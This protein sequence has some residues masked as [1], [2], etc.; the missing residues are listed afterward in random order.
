MYPTT[1]QLYRCLRRHAREQQ[2]NKTV[3]TRRKR[4]KLSEDDRPAHKQMCD[5]TPHITHLTCDG[6]GYRSAFDMSLDGPCP[7]QTPRWHGHADATAKF[8]FLGFP[9][10]P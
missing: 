1:K 6:L 7:P 2:S 10:L 5:E 8:D 4:T 9:P 3:H